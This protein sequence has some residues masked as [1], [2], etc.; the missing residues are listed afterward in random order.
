MVLKL[1]FYYSSINL[2][3]L[4]QFYTCTISSAVLSNTFALDVDYLQL[5]V[6][7]APYTSLALSSSRSIFDM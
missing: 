1:T 3:I 4:L 2:D 6:G 5:L 7:T